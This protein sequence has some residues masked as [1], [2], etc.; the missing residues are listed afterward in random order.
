MASILITMTEDRESDR[1]G[2]FVSIYDIDH[3][4]GEAYGNALVDLGHNV[5][6]GNWDDFDGSQFTRVYDVGKGIF[7]VSLDLAS[8]HLIFVYKM[9]GFLKDLPRF[10]NM[11]DCFEQS[12]A[13]VVNDPKTIRHNI[14]KQYLFELSGLG[15]SVVPTFELDQAELLLDKFEKLVVKPKKGER[16]GAQELVTSGAQLNKYDGLESGYIVQQ[17][18]PFVSE[19][20]VSLVFLGHEYHHAVLKKP[21]HGHQGEYRCNGCLGGYNEPYKAS[22]GEIEFG[23]QVLRAYESL[24]FPIHFSRIDYIMGDSGPVLIEAELLNPAVFSNK[25]NPHFSM[26]LG[27]YFS[28]LM[29]NSDRM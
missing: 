5:F 22:T 12:G 11:V 15:I 14:D 9:E 29:G 7:S 3:R 8:V 26:A 23:N 27:K 1:H 10:F 21:N 19:G 17:F 2:K 4:D 20:E 18:L 28:S 6:Y 16:G 13:I 25:H 24:G